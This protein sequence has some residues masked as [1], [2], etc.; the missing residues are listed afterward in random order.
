[1]DDD[2]LGVWYVTVDNEIA[3]RCVVCVCVCVFFN[4]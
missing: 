4:Y 2:G 3:L 1:M